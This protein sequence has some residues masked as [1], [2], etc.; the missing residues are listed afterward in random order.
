MWQS[1]FVRRRWKDASN[2]FI[3]LGGFMGE[4]QPLTRCDKEEADVMEVLVE[5]DTLACIASSIATSV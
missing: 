5:T 3:R 2:S 4:G 1:C